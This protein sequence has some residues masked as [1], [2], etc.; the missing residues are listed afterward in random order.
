MAR[1]FAAFWPR[2]TAAMEAGPG[3]P[4][5]EDV[6]EGR[7]FRPAALQVLPEAG[8]HRMMGLLDP[9]A[10]LLLRRAERPGPLVELGFQRSGLQF[11]LRP[12]AALFVN[13]E[14]CS[15]EGAWWSRADGQSHY[16]PR[17]CSTRECAPKRAIEG[18]RADHCWAEILLRGPLL[19]ETRRAVDCANTLFPNNN[20]DGPDRRGDPLLAKAAIDPGQP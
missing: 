9:R 8:P 4:E 12:L 3:W 10:A 20:S 15:R 16:L 5:S 13:W 19:P 2:V 1:S 11:R 14:S 7:Q 18:A 6:M 17:E